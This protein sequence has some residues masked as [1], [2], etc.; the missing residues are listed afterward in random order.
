MLT[1]ESTHTHIIMARPIARVTDKFDVVTFLADQYLLEAVTSI[2]RRL[3]EGYAR[4]NPDLV[5][6]IVKVMQD[7]SFVNK[8]IIA[9][10]ND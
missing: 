3:G 7:C 6:T 5:A 9:E 8:G 2:D 1:C 10:L 4:K